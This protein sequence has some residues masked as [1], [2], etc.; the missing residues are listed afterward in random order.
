MGAKNH[1]LAF[2]LPFFP[3]SW[4]DS[5]SLHCD[6]SNTFKQMFLKYTLSKLVVILIRE[7]F[8]ENRFRKHKSLAQDHTGSGSKIS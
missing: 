5:V 7:L 6:L 8:Q 2:Y 4:S 3:T 1:I